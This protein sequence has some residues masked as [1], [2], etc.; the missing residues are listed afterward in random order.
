ME[1][2]VIVHNAGAKASPENIIMT[3]R[4]AEELGYRS[5]WLTDHVVLA[6][7]VNAWYPYRTH[8]RWD[9]SPDTKWI[10]P[11][12]TLAWAGAAVPRLKLGTS[13][14]VIPLR[15]PVLL[16]KQLA[17]LDFLTGGRVILGVG[18]GWMEEEFNLIGENFANRGKR[19][20]EMVKLMRELWTGETVDFHGEFYQL[21]GC[22]MHPRP[23]Q[24]TIPVVWGGHSDAAIKRA[25][26]VGDG[27]HPTQISLAQLEEG[28]K[29]LRQY[30]E[31]YGRDPESV[32]VF[33]R[34]GD[35]YEIN[36]ESH[37]RHLE[38]GIDHLIVDTPIKQED[39]E[40]KLLRERMERVAEICGL[41][42][43]S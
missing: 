30:C 13:V 34:P 8:G 5:L 37:A 7:E 10:D 23:V 35:N 32:S 12:L 31:E 1:V 4:W 14:L 28:I 21:S 6:E 26:K 22:K 39:P 36:A 29:K 41:T 33:A 9:Y 25:A 43:R 20:V 38:L 19:A 15:N 42:P 16:A 40:L 11:L 18:A 2:G 3:A 24:P 17:S 27:W